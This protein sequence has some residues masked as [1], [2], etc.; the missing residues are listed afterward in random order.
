MG[1]VIELRKAEHLTPSAQVL[2][3]VNSNCSFFV[4]PYFQH[5]L[6]NWYQFDIFDTSHL[7]KYI[8]TSNNKQKN[9]QSHKCLPGILFF[10]FFFA[11]IL[12][13]S[14][15]FYVVFQLLYFSRSPVRHLTWHRF[16]E[17]GKVERFIRK[18]LLHRGTH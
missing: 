1:N 7:L 13:W 5:Q 2:K 11:N 15:E 16:M 17:K 3:S 14:L 6:V 9:S 4:H 8:Q 18:F 12:N 10:H